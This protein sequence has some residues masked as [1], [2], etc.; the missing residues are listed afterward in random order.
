MIKRAVEEGKES[1]H[2]RTG[3][4]AMLYSEYESSVSPLM[5]MM[6]V[7]VWSEYNTPYLAPAS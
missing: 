6:V 5:M 1:T 4:T 7:V 2:Q 3:Y